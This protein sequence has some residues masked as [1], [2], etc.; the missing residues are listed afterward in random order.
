[1]DSGFWFKLVSLLAQL[2]EADQKPPVRERFVRKQ[3][4]MKGQRR[5]T[6]SGY[7]KSR[8]DQEVS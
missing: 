7:R 8:E 2:Q 3:I 5:R 1:M 4:F 6:A